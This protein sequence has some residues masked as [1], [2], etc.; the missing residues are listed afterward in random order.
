MMDNVVGADYFC[1]L[2]SSEE[3][4]ISALL[5]HLDSN[6]EQSFFKTIFDFL[7]E[8][9]IQSENIRFEKNKVS[10]SAFSD[11]KSVVPVFVVIP[12]N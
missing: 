1:L 7:G 8:K 5:S 6:R 10:F 11:G 12:H 9:I 2:Y 3:I 4:D